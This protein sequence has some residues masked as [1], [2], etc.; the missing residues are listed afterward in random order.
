MLSLT[1]IQAIVL[2]F[3]LARLSWIDLRTFRLPDVYTLPLILAGLILATGD[4][5]IGLP[6][7]LLGCLLGFALFWVVGQ[8]YFWRTGQEGLGLGDAKLFAAS[9]AWLG[10]AALP[11]VLLIA[12]LGGW[13][14]YGCAKTLSGGKSHSVPGWHLDSGWSGSLNTLPKLRRH[15]S[16]K[17]NRWPHP[18]PD[19]SE[20]VGARGQRSA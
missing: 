14:F 8:Y 4:K 11:Y 3:V 15:Q 20:A 1:Y 13:C 6:A 5:G 18:F 10:P 16:Y 12:A 17:I 2:T 9:G 7:S 19:A